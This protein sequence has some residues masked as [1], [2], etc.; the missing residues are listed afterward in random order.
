MICKAVN[1][2]LLFVLVH[3]KNHKTD[4]IHTTYS[5]VR[6]DLD[7][8]R[9]SLTNLRTPCGPYFTKVKSPL[10]GT[11]FPR[12]HIS[13]GKPNNCKTTHTVSDYKSVTSS[14]CVRACMH[15]SE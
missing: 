4:I 14:V 1:P 12:V 7:R 10:S 9:V 8:I 15:G 13:P 11:M 5:Y 6:A 3:W 2:L